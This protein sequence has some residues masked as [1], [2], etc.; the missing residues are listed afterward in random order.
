MLIFA[1]GSQVT[2]APLQAFSLVLASVAENVAAG[3]N[4]LLQYVSHFLQTAGIQGS[5]HSTPA[6]SHSTISLCNMLPFFSYFHSGY[7][8]PWSH[9]RRSGLCHPVGAGCSHRILDALTRV[10]PGDQDSETGLLA[11][12]SQCSFSLFCLHPEWPQREYRDHSHPN[13][14]SGA[15]LFPIGC[16]TLRGHKCDW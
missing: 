1:K 9:S 11:T 3:L 8:H 7:S 16:W 4:V 12:E 6:S 10:S 2:C 14:R 5:F 15:G 13:G